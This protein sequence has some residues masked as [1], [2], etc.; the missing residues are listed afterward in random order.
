VS[1]NPA[2]KIQVDPKVL[3]AYFL[4]YWYIVLIGLIIGLIY[5]FFQVRY[6][7]STYSVNSRM[8][9]KDEY[10]SW[11]QEY[12]LPGMEL[13]SGR[14][15]LINEIGVIRSSPLM[16]KVA[17]N[18]NRSISYYKIG[19]IK[20]TE[21]YP[22]YDFSLEILERNDEN[23]AFFI[24]FTAKNNFKISDSKEGIENAKVSDSDSI[25]TWKG[26]KYAFKKISSKVEEGDLYLVK[27]ESDNQI[28][29]RLQAQIGI[30]VENQ[31]SSILILTHSGPTP[32]KSIDYLNTLMETYISW[33]IEQNNTIATNTISFVD[34]QLKE[35]A[36][37]LVITEYRL[38]QFQKRNFEE[39]I[40]LEEDQSKLSR[41]SELEEIK[42]E[43]AV[44]KEYYSAL[45]QTLNQ[46][47]FTAFPSAAVF[48]FED[49]N[50]DRMINSLMEAIR[51]REEV[52]LTFK[53]NA[54]LLNRAK[55]EVEKRRRDLYKATV[56]NLEQVSSMLDS[57]ELVIQKEE[58]RVLKIPKEQREFFKLQREY[59]LLSDLYTFLLNK[60]SEASIAKASNVEK[61]Q[62]LDYANG[63]RVRF[64]GPRVGNIYGLS[65]F[66]GF[67]IPM[68]I[69]FMIYLLN[70]KIIDQAEL[71][72]LTDIPVIGTIL[73]KKNIQN[74]IIVADSLKSVMAESFRSIRTNLNFM[75]KKKNNFKILITSSVG[76]EGKTFTSI[77]LSAIYAASGKRTVLLGADLRKPKIYE[78]FGL[79]NTIG[80]SS[81][82]IGQADLGD[83]IQSTR[84]ENLD[85]I[86]GGPIPP[87]PAELI[88]S[89]QME[90]L[91]NEL[92]SIYDVVI[93]DSPPLGLVID[94]LLLN[95]FADAALY[96]VRHNYTQKSYL[97]N[98]NQ[99]YK[100]KAISNLGIV[101]NALKPKG[102]I[103]KYSYGNTYGYG[104]GYGYGYYSDEKK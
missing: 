53:P 23:Q 35:I 32:E 73:L 95:K 92:E 79:T 70:T 15:R 17:E 30:D 43:R 24:A 39:R 50:I 63:Y 84:I 76:G 8:L 9:V 83:V 44:Q 98:I 87:N 10:S 1:Q 41:V 96:I 91:M 57:M 54:I 78:D 22:N 48:G 60:R 55:E 13:V 67:G 88:E 81:Y 38:E 40:F 99:L 19:N 71:E 20:T 46:E 47:D 6:T 16:Q 68:M 29:R 97:K 3:M 2:T 28:A 49:P 25:F 82:L 102:T 89:N 100:D 62:I 69:L 66:L 75:V 58:E 14:N 56:S 77:N 36:D 31:E 52:A 74:N 34:K 7:P 64:I 11:G 59:K 93:I 18:L 86:S 72:R 12:F 42:T 101:V 5:A 37:S 85:L 90:S 45:K 94:A 61:A 104:Y 27:V 33:G 4:R 103:G 65:I 26:N 80:L 51:E 21:N